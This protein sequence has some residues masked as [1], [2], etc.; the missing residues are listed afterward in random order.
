MYY[1]IIGV[2]TYGMFDP[3]DKADLTNL[4]LGGTQVGT[5][6]TSHNEFPYDWR[7]GHVI[8]VIFLCVIFMGTIILE[9]KFFL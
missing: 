6:L 4:Q 1:D 5:L 9:G 8:Y 2:S 7:H 3:D